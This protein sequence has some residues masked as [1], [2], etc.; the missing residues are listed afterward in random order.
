MAVGAAGAGG[1]GVVGWGAQGGH[2]STSRR[3]A[4]CA[5][6]PL[7]AHTQPSISLQGPSGMNEGAA[8]MSK[9]LLASPAA[10]GAWGA[11]A[12]AAARGGGWGS[13]WVGGRAE[14]GP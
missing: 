3:A 1:G 9:G 10:M 11:A 6:K 8:G 14:R 13:R 2:P 12:A 4:P 7:G 5:L